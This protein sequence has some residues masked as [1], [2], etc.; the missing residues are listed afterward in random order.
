MS[1]PD[2]DK[3]HWTGS[4]ARNNLHLP[5]RK[6]CPERQDP[7]RVNYWP[8]DGLYYQRMKQATFILFSLYF[9]VVN[10]GYHACFCPQPEPV[11]AHASCHKQQGKP[12]SE[13]GTPGAHKDCRGVVLKVND[14]SQLQVAQELVVKPASRDLPSFY[15]P[16]VWPSYHLVSSGKPAFSFHDPPPLRSVR[17]H[18]F[19][20]SLLL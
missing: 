10:T 16:D 7:A 2:P 5:R 14:S 4:S 19:N 3:S 13:E 9:L 20:R 6:T 11:P 17:L 15:V 12:C 18:L 8:G 1:I